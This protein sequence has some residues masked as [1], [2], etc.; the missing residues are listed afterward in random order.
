MT[1]VALT[2]EEF[3]EKKICVSLICGADDL[4]GG[5]Y[6]RKFPDQKPEDLMGLLSC[7]TCHLE[8]LVSNLGT[9]NMTYQIIGYKGY[10]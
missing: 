6:Y 5:E 1:V 4:A 10:A 9:S 2:Q 3:R 7:E 8:I